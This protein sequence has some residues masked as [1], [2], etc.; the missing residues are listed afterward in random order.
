[1]VLESQLS[2]KSV[3]LMFQIRNTKASS[4]EQVR[5]RMQEEIEQGQVWGCNPV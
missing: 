4:L 1:M 3:N 2:H 5:G